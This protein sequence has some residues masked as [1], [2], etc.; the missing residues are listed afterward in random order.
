MPASVGSFSYDPVTGIY[1]LTANGSDIFGTAD[2][3]DFAYRRLSGV[4]TIEA[5]VLSIAET[6]T[7]SKGGV[8]I[9]EDLGPNSAFA[10]AYITGSQGCRFQARFVKGEEPQSE[11]PGSGDNGSEL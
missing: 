6:D 5:Q 9:R 11:N 1:T 10:A 4:G 8:M 7:W 2:E 3:F